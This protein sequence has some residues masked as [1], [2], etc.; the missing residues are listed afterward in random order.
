MQGFLSRLLAV[1]AFAATGLAA[2]ALASPTATL[3]TSVTSCNPA[4]GTVNFS[5]NFSYSG[6]A[7]VAVSLEVNVPAGWTYADT[8]GSTVP[9]ITPA[10]N[11]TTEFDWAYISVPANGAQFSFDAGYAA[12]LTGIQTITAVAYIGLSDGSIVTLNLPAI[13]IGSAP[14]LASGQTITFGGLSGRTYGAVPFSVS[15]T[16]SSGLPVTISVATGP[17]TASGS[18]ITITG[19]GI[20]TVTAAQAGN[21]S[22]NAAPSVSQPFMVAKGTASVA[23]GG[24]NQTFCGDAMAPTVTTVPAGLGT[25]IT[26]NGS[27]APPT[28]AAT[29]AVVATI[30]DPNYQGS[31]SGTFTINAVL[32]TSTA[33]LVNLSA[34]AYVGTGG[35]ILIA[36]FGIGGAGTKQVVLRGVGPGMG[37]TFGITDDLTAAVLTIFDGGSGRGETAP[38]MIAANQ[39]WANSLTLGNSPVVAVATEAAAPVMAGLGAFA[40]SPDSLDSAVLTSL[41]TGNYTSQVSGAGGATGVALAEIYDADPGTPSARLV[42]I[43]ARASVGTGFNIL[44]AGFAISGNSSE[45]VLIRGIGPGLNTLFGLPGVLTN[46]QLSL[47]DGIGSGHVIATNSGWSVAPT[48]GPSTVVAVIQP[49]TSPAMAAVGAFPLAANSADAA[50]LVTLPPGSYTA[51]LSGAAGSTGIG[52]IEVYEAP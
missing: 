33:R 28:A 16:A 31:T 7:V 14:A 49:A 12:G 2:E 4:G 15:A 25:S 41:P 20:V 45:T 38:E 40:L 27:L 47:Y 3:T 9:G 21:A 23:L 8:N 43:S 52:L 17:A 30:T 26:Y 51:Q 5:A 32:P 35:N 22:Y 10:A 42:N 13:T 50:M 37:S 6:L 19:A 1:I 46:P 48:T 44:I 36:G 29:Y 24:L 39:G 34:R 11:A 18:M